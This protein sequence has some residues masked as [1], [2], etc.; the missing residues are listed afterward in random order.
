MKTPKE[1][2][3][4]AAKNAGQHV[5]KLSEQEI[6]FTKKNERDILAE[7]DLQSEEIILSAIKLNFPTYSILSEE[8]GSEK[9]TSEYFWIVDPIDGTINYAKGSEDY[10]ISIAF[11][12]RDEIILGVIYQPALDKL[13][14][15]EKGKGAYLNGKRISVSSENE[16]I[17]ALAA[18]DNTSKSPFQTM[19][20]QQLVQISTQVRQIRILGSVALHLAK[21]AEGQLDFY[22]K[23]R[24]HYWDLA[25]GVLLVQEA[26]GKVTDFTGNICKE[27]SENL[28]ASNGKLHEKALALITTK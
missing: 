25:A 11:S 27:I 17:N 3:I 10:C 4:D 15:A 14:V 16:T 7:A 18:T 6:K 21:V 9:Q 1:I 23:K 12:H 8:A 20:F 2:A 24:G 19:N 28:L 5:L 13:Y 22:F 26:G